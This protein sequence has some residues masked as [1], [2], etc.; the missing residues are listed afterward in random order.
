[1]DRANGALTFGPTTGITVEERVC[2]ERF[3]NQFVVY[4]TQCCGKEGCFPGHHLLYAVNHQLGILFDSSFVEKLD[5]HIQDLL[6]TGR[7]P[8][9]NEANEKDYQTPTSQQRRKIVLVRR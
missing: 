7:G 1:M 4:Q 6:V 5:F 9:K 3:F 8:G 2:R